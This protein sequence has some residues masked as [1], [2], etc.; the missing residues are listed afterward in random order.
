MPKWCA[1]SCTTVT[2]TSCT[3][4]SLSAQIV[5]D[6]VLVDRDPVGE[7]AAVVAGPLGERDALVQPQQLRVRRV[8]LLD[9]HDDVVHRRQQ[10]RRDRVERVRDE[11]VELPRRGRRTSVC[12]YPVADERRR[13]RRQRAAR[14]QRQPTS[15]RPPAPVVVG[16]RLGRAVAAGAGAAAWASARARLGRGVAGSATAGLAGGP[17]GRR[18]P[19]VRRGGAGWSPTDTAPLTDPVTGANPLRSGSSAARLQ[20]TLREPAF[21]ESSVMLSQ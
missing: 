20:L 1:I 19:G 9:E 7:H 10:V 12:R 16:C 2:A 11:L 13:R 15:R 21:H 3:T 14:R 5:D 18:A 17:P 4:S 6:R 8:A